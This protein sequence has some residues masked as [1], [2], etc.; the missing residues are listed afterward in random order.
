M[1][2]WLLLTVLLLSASAGGC[3]DPNPTFVFD[4]APA[5]NRDGGT[6]ADASSTDGGQDGDDASDDASTDATGGSQ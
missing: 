5:T 6:D 4:A 2:R 1:S 3:T